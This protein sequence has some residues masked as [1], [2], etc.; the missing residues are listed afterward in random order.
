MNIIF[1]LIFWLCAFLVLYTYFL[2]PLILGVL[3]IFIRRPVRKSDIVPYVS[4]IIAAYNEE[5]SIANKIENSLNLDY[6]KSKLQIIVASD[7]SDDSTDKIVLSFKDRGVILVRQNKRL[8]KTSTQN[9]A[10]Q[11]AK[12]EVILF[13][14]AT[15]R[16]RSDVIRKI[17]RNF[18][19]ESVGCVGAMLKYSDD[20]KSKLGRARRIYWEYEKF[21]RRR[22]SNLNSLLGVSGCCYA[23]RKK[24]YKAMDPQLI[25][26]FVISWFVVEQGYRSVFESEAQ[27]YEDIVET[28]RDEVN[29]RTRVVGRSIVAIKL[30]KRFLNP[31]RFG[32]FSFQLFSHKILRYCVPIF[33]ILI[34]ISNLFLVNIEPYRFFLITQIA[35]IGLGLVSLIFREKSIFYPLAYFIIGNLSILKGFLKSTSGRK[36]F[37]IWQPLRR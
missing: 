33:I 21:L 34:F 31:L 8:G 5:K 14:D 6:P 29:M 32:F 24:V 15:T 16:L 26:D 35:F 37:D 25:S 20:K 10:V 3:S 9:Q 36:K 12:G 23:V 11:F 19:D 13:T 22:E 7:C 28:E 4:L 30:M 2:Y 27:V 18:A 1:I 17:V